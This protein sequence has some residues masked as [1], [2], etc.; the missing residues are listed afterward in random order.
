MVLHMRFFLCVFATVKR[1]VVYGL[2]VVVQTFISQSLLVVVKR[3]V[4]YGLLVVVQSVLCHTLHV[5]P[6]IL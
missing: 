5:F 4:V 6:R 3:F 2:L 1:F